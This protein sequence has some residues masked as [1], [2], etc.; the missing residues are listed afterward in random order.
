VS[1]AGNGETAN[2]AHAP[3]LE[4]SRVLLGARLRAIR[5][6][7]FLYSKRLGAVRPAFASVRR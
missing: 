6:A 3:H 4:A 2:A 1:V 5:E 7:D